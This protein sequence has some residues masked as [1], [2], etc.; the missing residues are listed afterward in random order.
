MADQYITC[1]NYYEIDEDQLKEL[2]ETDESGYYGSALRFYQQ[3][4]D[5]RVSNLTP[6][7]KSWMEKIDDDLLVK[8][9]S[10]G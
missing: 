2:V 4:K 7:Q 5:T 9:R 1:K 3:N 6:S 10:N 8:R